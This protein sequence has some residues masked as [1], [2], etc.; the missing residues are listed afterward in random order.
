MTFLSQLTLNPHNG[1]VR[2]E[3]S[4]PYE[5][6]RTLLKAFPSE[7]VNH[8][9]DDDGSH[10]LLFRLSEVPR[11]TVL[12]QSRIAPDWNKL[13]TGY[14]LKIEGPLAFDLAGKLTTGQLWAFRLRA[15]PTKR[16]PARCPGEKRDGKRKPIFGDEAQLDW[17]ARKGQKHGFEVLRE[18]VRLR[19][20]DHLK[21]VKTDKYGKHLMQW[22]SIQF[23][24][25]LRVVNAEAL[26]QA[27]E[28]GIGTAK[29]MGFGLLSLSPLN[30][31][32]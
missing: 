16:E 21:G 9:R 29:G 23:D 30:R 25:V 2:A 6:H 28:C 32:S 22:L 1:Q 19:D 3:L 24:G 4:K 13:V 15:N 14:L 11:L 10:G 27:V 17:L 20:D 26:Q 5:M 18:S 31:Q 7:K 8:Q 12:V